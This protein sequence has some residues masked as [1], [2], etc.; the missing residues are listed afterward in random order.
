M[1]LRELLGFL[2]VGASVLL[3]SLLLLLLLLGARRLE[4]ADGGGMRVLPAFG[5]GGW[6]GRGAAGGGIR[7]LGFVVGGRCCEGCL[8]EGGCGEGD[9]VFSE[10]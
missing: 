4:A 9:V 5:C 1:T 7:E 10:A 6:R 8:R 2:R 3:L